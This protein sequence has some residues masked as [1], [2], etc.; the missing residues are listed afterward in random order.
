MLNE[1][2]NQLMKQISNTEEE[3]KNKKQAV[4]LNCANLQ[5]IKEKNDKIQ[6]A[7][8]LTEKR[9]QETQNTAAE[10]KTKLEQNT[11]HF[12]ASEEAF[13][14]LNTELKQ[15][16][17]KLSQSE[18][19]RA[20]ALVKLQDYEKT[21]TDIKIDY[22]KKHAQLEKLSYEMIGKDVEQR[23]DHKWNQLAQHHALEKQEENVRRRTTTTATTTTT[24]TK[25]I[26]ITFP[27]RNEI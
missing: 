20:Q 6:S 2:D 9:F 16:N 22:Y 21:M 25:A 19:K 10:V 7:H 18:E 8:Q 11:S 27:K 4:E 26:R 12:S 24:T 15:S 5:K 23:S 1:R 3:L 13:K 17:D 14:K